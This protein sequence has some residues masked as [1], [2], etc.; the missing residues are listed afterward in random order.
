MSQLDFVCT[1]LMDGRDVSPW[2]KSVEIST[3]DKIDRKF[4]IVF[5]SWDQFSEANRWDI[6]GS[7]NPS[8]PNQE[9]LIRNG[10]IPIDR[11]RS[12]SVGVGAVPQVIG[13]GYDYVWLAKRKAPRKTIV[14]MPDR[15]DYQANLKKAVN[16][17]Q[18]RNDGRPI[19]RYQVWP[20]MT[21]LHKALT[22]LA[23]AGGIHISIQI[24]NYDL[25]PY[26]VD[27][28]FS[29]WAAIEELASPFAPNIYYVRQNNTL[30]IADRQSEV[31]HS[32]NKLTLSPK[33]VAD[34]TAAP[35]YTRRIRR[36]IMRIPAWR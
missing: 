17:F 25:A 14:M 4:T 3:E 5:S 21:N 23:H 19:G 16:D 32:S 15:R 10:R 29:Y 18:E 12:V 9:I 8:Q 26:V 24:P 2:V 7:Y 11:W 13:T 30:V 6:Y 20:S 28:K 34:L 36:V 27:P 22:R 33:I 1:V 35:I 31:M